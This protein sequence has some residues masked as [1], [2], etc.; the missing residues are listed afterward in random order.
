MPQEAH[1]PGIAELPG[2]ADTVGDGGS[3]GVAGVVGSAGVEDGGAAVGDGCAVGCGAEEPG[4]AGV[5][6]GPAGRPRPGFAEVTACEAP[7][8][9]V[10]ETDGDGDI[11]PLP[12][13]GAL[14]PPA[15]FAPSATASALAGT[16]RGAL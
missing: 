7:G 5:V 12:G 15:L 13:R 10:P 11:G 6:P 3:D 14:P 4:A 1:C 16:G 8:E 9:T 2:S